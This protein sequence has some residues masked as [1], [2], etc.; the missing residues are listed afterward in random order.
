MH[1]ANK[2]VVL[3]HLLTKRFGCLIIIKCVAFHRC[4]VCISQYEVGDLLKKLPCEHEFHKS[5]L[6]SWFSAS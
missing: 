1:L 6:E 5:C 3:I 4:A 2:F